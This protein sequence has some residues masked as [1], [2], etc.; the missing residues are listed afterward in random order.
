MKNSG[1][2][3]NFTKL[4]GPGA[5]H[6]SLKPYNFACACLTIRQYQVTDHQAPLGDTFFIENQIPD[7]AVHF[8]YGPPGNF[9]IIRRVASHFSISHFALRKVS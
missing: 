9:R 1:Y 3:G 6:F 2:P 8:P 5:R 4:I 7:L